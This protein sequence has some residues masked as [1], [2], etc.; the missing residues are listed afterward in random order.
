LLQK[1]EQLDK[2]FDTIKENIYYKLVEE[3]P[4]NEVVVKPFENI[5]LTPRG[6]VLEW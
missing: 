2:E 1:Q 6:F 5:K 3:T 4:K